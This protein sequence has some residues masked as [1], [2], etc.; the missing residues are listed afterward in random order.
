[1]GRRMIGETKEGESGK[2]KE[3]NAEEDKHTFLLQHIWD[4][5]WVKE[6]YD[7]GHTNYLW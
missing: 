1:M 7:A 2:N 4:D 3:R 6:S 5:R